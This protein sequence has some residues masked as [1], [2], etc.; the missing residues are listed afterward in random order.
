MVVY[1]KDLGF[2]MNLEPDKSPDAS[3][4][5]NRW[6]IAAPDIPILLAISRTGLRASSIKNRKI[7]LSIPSIL[8]K[9]VGVFMFYQNKHKCT[10]LVSI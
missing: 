3:N 7:F 6:C 9:E 8:A 4:F 2:T 5:L 1:P 10:Y